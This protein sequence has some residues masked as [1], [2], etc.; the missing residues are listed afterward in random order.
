MML[1]I[2]YSAA[3]HYYLQMVSLVSLGN[4]GKPGL[5]F[6]CVLY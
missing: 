5:D 3:M 6:L 1:G 2:L 4:L